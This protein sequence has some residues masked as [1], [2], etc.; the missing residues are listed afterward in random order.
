VGEEAEEGRASR[1]EQEIPAVV[2]RE[3]VRHESNDFWGRARSRVVPLLGER[4]DE[5][6]GRGAKGKRKREGVEDR[7]GRVEEHRKSIQKRRRSGR[8]LLAFFGG[9]YSQIIFS[10][11]SL[12]YGFNIS[13]RSDYGAGTPKRSARISH[14][15]HD[16]SRT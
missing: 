7:V 9:S 13:S 4:D 5:E 14:P 2:V 16:L 8:P 6:M 11:L 1:G 12:D 15:F 3:R 10:R